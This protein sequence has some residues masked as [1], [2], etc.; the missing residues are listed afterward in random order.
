MFVVFALL[1][2]VVLPIVFVVG[3][4]RPDTFAKLSGGL[5]RS[6]GKGALASLGMAIALFIGAGI[7]APEVTPTNEA[8]LAVQSSTVTK[9]AAPKSEPMAPTPPQVSVPKESTPSAS[10][11]AKSSDPIKEQPEAKPTQKPAPQTPAVPAPK[12][13]PPKPAPA[14]K[15]QPKPAPKSSKCL[16]KGNISSSQEKIYHVPGGTYYNKTVIDTSKGERWFCSEAEAVR[17]GWRAS[18]R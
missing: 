1:L 15:P 12:V 3:M 6:R 17:A 14:P 10:T 18:K 16:I 4:V 5:V 8:N 9:P 11:N 13:V 7:T 2:F